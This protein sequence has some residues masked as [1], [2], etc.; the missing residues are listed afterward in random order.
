MHETTWGLPVV[1]YL[2]MAGLGAGALTTS[3]SVLLRG[4]PTGKYFDV[5]RYGAF[6]APIPVMLGSALLVFELGSFQAGHWFRFLNLYMVINMSPMS[7]GTWLL[8]AFLGVSILYAYTFLSRDAAPGDSKEKLRRMTAWVGI[9]LGIGVAVYTGVL[10]GALPARPFWNSPILALLFLLS[11]LSTGIASIILVRAIM[12]RRQ[13]NDAAEANYHE[14]GYILSTTDTLLIGL[15]LMTIFLFLMYAHLT[16]GHTRD[17]VGVI[18][19]GGE[20]SIM[21]WFWVIAIGLLIPAGI[22]LAVIIPRMIHQGKYLSHR[23]I[24]I[25]V[26]VTVLIGGFMLR[27]VV[28]I[29]GQ[30]TFPIGL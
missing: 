11:S 20:L 1:L 15:E 19:F 16:I 2:F 4:G 21:F 22:E 29:A 23:Y 27:Y 13:L 6:I 18:M 9:P 14:S 17:A 24:D 25:I 10:L 5:A 28:L 3:A 8:T 26:P 30:I 12:H 7:I